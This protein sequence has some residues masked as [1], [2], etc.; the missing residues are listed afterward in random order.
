MTRF[1]PIGAAEC[2]VELEDFQGATMRIQLRG[3]A[4]PDLAALARSF[5]S[6]DS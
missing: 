2:T 5:W 3:Y 1:G 4:A 6:S